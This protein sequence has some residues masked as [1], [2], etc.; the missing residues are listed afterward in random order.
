M[1]LQE[2]SENNS[3]NGRNHQL[4]IVP[5]NLIAILNKI[6]SMFLQFLQSGS[7]ISLQIVK[8]IETRG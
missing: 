7:M 3:L 6:I 1:F 5:E 2:T 4:I 8:N